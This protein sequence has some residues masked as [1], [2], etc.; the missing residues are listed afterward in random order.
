MSLDAPLENAPRFEAPSLAPL[1][2]RRLSDHVLPM[3]LVA[4]L[5]VLPML[6]AA[7]DLDYYLS[8]LRRVMIMALAATSLNLLVGYGGMFAL[9]HA[10]F[11]GVGAYA[12][13]ALTEAGLV[14]AWTIWP[15]SAAI[16]ALAAAAIGSI[17]LRAKGV[18]FI[19]STLAFAQMLYYLASSLRIYGGDDG[20]SLTTLPSLGA[21]LDIKD[22]ATFYGVV[23]IL[24]TACFAGTTCFLRSRFGRALCAVRDNETRMTA[25]GYPVFKIR[26]LTFVL[27]GAVAGLA[28]ALLV[29][30]NGFVSPSS[31]HWSQSA[32]MLVIVVLGGLGWRWGAVVGVCVWMVLEEVLRQW[33]EYWHWPL[34]VLLIII[35]LAAPRGLCALIASWRSNV[36]SSSHQAPPS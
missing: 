32:N 14:S 3:V 36:D 35:V 18:Y 15:L 22:D 21:G 25:L 27:A 31:M 26:F 5:L 1:A 6:T 28:G 7:V 30:H 10:G 17:A 33:T 4:L 16:A 29:T 19:M 13:V 24:V 9:G 11:M 20:H 2:S 23:V 12:V 8:F 34:G